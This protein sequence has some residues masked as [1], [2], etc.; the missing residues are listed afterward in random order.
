VFQFDSIS[1]YLFQQAIKNG[2]N[3]YR[4]NNIPEIQLLLH[5]ISLNHLGLKA[6]QFTITYGMILTV[7]DLPEKELFDGN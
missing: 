7:S 2:T 1:E 4:C 3:K 6:K 5:D